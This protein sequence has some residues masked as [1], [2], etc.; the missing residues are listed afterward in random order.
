MTVPGE[1]LFGAISLVAEQVVLKPVTG[2]MKSDFWRASRRCQP[3]SVPE[4]AY[5]LRF[6]VEGLVRLIQSL[7][8]AHP[9][10]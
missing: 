6:G 4:S 5:L 3:E 7:H 10:I 1:L 9:M 8:Q 2:P